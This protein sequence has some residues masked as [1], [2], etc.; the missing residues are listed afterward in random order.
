MQPHFKPQR[1]IKLCPLY[2]YLIRC[3][4]TVRTAFLQTQYPGKHAIL[5]NNR[6][7]ISLSRYSLEKAFSTKE[8]TFCS[9]IVSFVWSFL[10]TTIRKHVRVREKIN[11]KRSPLKF[12]A[13]KGT[14]KL[15]DDSEVWKQNIGKKYENDD[16]CHDRRKHRRH[17]QPGEK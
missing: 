9:I 1:I 2:G 7:Y 3:K 15:W 16:R 10:S 12:L 4:Q 11:G 17:A 8:Y 13:Q 14:D 6:N 5:E